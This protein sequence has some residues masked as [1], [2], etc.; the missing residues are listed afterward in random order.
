MVPKHTI[1]LAIVA[2]V[3]LTST[4]LY[5]GELRGYG[6]VEARYFAN[7][8]L[9]EPQ[10]QHSAAVAAQLEY[11]HDFDD[12]RQRIAFTGFGRIDSADD[13]RTH[14]D[15]RELYWWKDFT[16]FELYGGIRKVYWGVTESVH[17]VD[18]INQDDVIESLDREEK[19]G[20]PMLQ[21]VSMRDWGTLEAFVL[22]GFREQQFPGIHGRLRPGIP[23][24]DNAQYESSKEDEHIDIALRWSHYFGNWDIGLSHFS[25]TN[26][27]PIFLPESSINGDITLRPYYSLIDQTGLDIQATIDAWLWKL[28][29]ITRNEKDYDSTLASVAGLEYTVFNLRDTNADIGLIAE[30]Q[31]DDAEGARESTSQNDIAL[32]VRWAFNDLD[33][34]TVLALVNQD[35]DSTNRFYSVEVSRRITDDW[36]LEAEARFFTHI[37]AGTPEYDFRDDDYFQIEVRRYF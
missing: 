8:P 34:S 5:A 18:I 27:D 9:F 4:T 37:E 30:Y 12:A 17:L 13:H 11:Y 29:V 15:I 3:T 28:E 23:V 20:Q 7:T 22:L 26:R 6:G 32:G 14:A 16:H 19:L 36:T 24:L 2:T 1:T 10:E 35:L 31:F 21:L 33:G 25:G